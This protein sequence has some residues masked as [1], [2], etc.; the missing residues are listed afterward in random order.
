MGPHSGFLA[1]VLPSGSRAVAIN[2]DAQGFEHGWRLY[3]AKT[4]ESM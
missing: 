3:S 1:A 4:T 2:I